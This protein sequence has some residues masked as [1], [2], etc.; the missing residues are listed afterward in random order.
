MKTDTYVKILITIIAICLIKIAFFTPPKFSYA[1]FPFFPSGDKT[2][3]VNLRS[4]DD[5]ELI[6]LKNGDLQIGGKRGPKII[7]NGALVVRIKKD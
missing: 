5:N 4:I 3:D 1:Q 6:F 7:E 2:I